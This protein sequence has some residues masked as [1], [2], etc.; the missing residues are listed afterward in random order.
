MRHATRSLLSLAATA[1]LIA[2]CGGSDDPGNDSGGA[3]AKPTIRNAAP[4]TEQ[5]VMDAAGLTSDDD[6]LSY[7]TSSGCNVSVVLTSKQAVDL[8]ADA[9]STVVTNPEGTAGVKTSGDEPDCLA[10]LQRGLSKL[11]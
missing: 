6:G 10:E 8:Y 1:A 2:G 5:Q 9:G 4:W 11:R 3:K 7:S